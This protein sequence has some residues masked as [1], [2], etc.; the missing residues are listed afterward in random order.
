MLGPGPNPNRNSEL[1]SAMPQ[2]IHKTMEDNNDFW[3]DIDKMLDNG[4]SPFAAYAQ[5]P[6]P[7][8]ATAPPMLAA[9]SKPNISIERSL[10]TQVDMVKAAM[11]TLVDKVGPKITLARFKKEA[12]RAWERKY[13]NSI[14]RTNKFQTFV[15]MNMKDIRSRNPNMTHSDHMKLIGRMWKADKTATAAP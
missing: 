9:E 14:G 1:N 10:S 6:L 5:V 3:D 12:I 2:K 13:P 7:L 11:R 15:K 8:E 4:T